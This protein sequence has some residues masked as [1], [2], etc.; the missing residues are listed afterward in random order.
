M[1]PIRYFEKIQ[2]RWGFDLAFSSPSPYNPKQRLRIRFYSIIPPNIKRQLR[3]NIE[4]NFYSELDISSMG[5]VDDTYKVL[6]FLNN[7]ILFFEDEN[8]TY[9][10]GLFLKKY[11]TTRLDKSHEKEVLKNF[12]R[13]FSPLFNH[14]K[15]LQQHL[16]ERL[17]SQV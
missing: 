4:K 5:V 3:R 10:S 6:S 7:H 1:V 14:E 2:D 11:Q 15:C 16:E 9:K 17:K 8:Y 12:G 13:I